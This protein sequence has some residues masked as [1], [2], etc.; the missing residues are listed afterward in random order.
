MGT[1]GIYYEDKEIEELEAKA[2]KLDAAEKSIATLCA[3]MFANAAE[4]HR[5]DAEIGRLKAQLAEAREVL[6]Q[7]LAWYD[8]HEQMDRLPPVVQRAR[9]IVEG[10]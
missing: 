2:A 6:R 8:G 4:L 7:V 3:V 5:A 1:A 9:A 10:T